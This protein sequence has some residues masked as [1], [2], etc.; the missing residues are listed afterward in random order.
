MKKVI[1]L[2]WALLFSLNLW[3]EQDEQIQFSQK[4]I[5]TYQD[6]AA[7]L[8]S[9]LESTLNTV[10][11]KI[12]TQKEKEIIINESFLKIFVDDQ[13]Q[14][15]DDLVELRTVPTNKNI[16]AYLKDIDFFFRQV[17]F[18]FT[19][20]DVSY[21]VSDSNYLFFKFKINR[22]LRAKFFNG[23]TINTNKIRFVEINFDDENQDLKIASI[24]TTKLN[25][26]EELQNWWNTLPN[27]W[28]QLF[29]GNRMLN[30]SVFLTDVFSYSDSSYVIATDTTLVIEIDTFLAFNQD[31]LF[32]NE[33]DTVQTILYD[34]TEFDSDQIYQHLSK[35]IALQEL[36]IPDSLNIKDLAPLSKLTKLKSLSIAGSPVE[37]LIPL[38]NLTKLEVL[39]CQGTQLKTLTPLRYST[40]LKYLNFSKTL[41][42]DLG[43]IVN[44]SFLERL[45]F[46]YTP[47]DDLKPL[48]KL[49]YIQDLRFINSNVRKLDSLKN[50][51]NLEILNITSTNVSSVEALS[52][53]EKLRILVIDSTRIKNLSPLEKNISLTKIYCDHSQINAE[54]ANRFMLIQ[55]DCLV[56]FESEELNSWWAS[57]DEVWKQTFRKYNDL[58][59]IPTT[60]QLHDLPKIKIINI[61]NQPTIKTLEPLRKLIG[62]EHLNCSNTAISD[63]DPLRDLIDLKYLDARKS[64]V[65]NLEPIQK[66]SK[67]EFLYLSNSHVF[68]VAHLEKLNDLKELHIENTNVASLKP[69]STLSQL[70][71]VYADNT[72]VDLI[73]VRKFRKRA[74][75]CLVVFRTRELRAWW[76]NLG[77][78]WEV[79]FRETAQI[80]SNPLSQEELHQI[81]T[82]EKIDIKNA[83]ELRNLNP[84][85][86]LSWL[87]ELRFSGTRITQLSP[88]KKIKSLELIECAD[89]PISD[90]SDIMKLPKLK[91]LDISNIP[92]ENFEQIQ[93]MK[94]LETLICPGTQVKN[95]KYLDTMTKLKH[96]EIYNTKIKNISPIEALK[97]ELLKC[98]NTNINPK[99][100][101]KFKSEHRKC[102][103]VFY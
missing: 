76:R 75:E 55:P 13:V 59:A 8:L 71:K 7:Q 67:L 58:D 68:E 85:T 57:L 30:D 43:P 23:D 65:Q 79:V 77:D 66:L 46:N 40:N 42:W 27:V 2:F 70:K 78:K 1:I 81:S 38:R 93:N 73:E 64:S 44:F 45:Y 61:S 35:F 22:N 96:L 32:I 91:Y 26:K 34:T 50:F 11:S 19:I 94:K 60:E 48:S 92:I 87:K 33:L 56:I 12:T 41:I 39:E 16:Q 31:T 69:V 6:Q 82:L 62:L 25:E 72:K 103:V 100:I 15:E 102:E 29:G 83:L 5:E 21:Q 36:E 97:L 63:L 52:G 95:L 98:Y 101:D 4:D 9:F 49:E 37:S 10:G 54:E 80:N 14:V 99:K 47:I 53:L 84:L 28:K 74:P 20:E 88:L 51:H 24:Y 90:L 18:K 17:E 89:N 86:T 3:A